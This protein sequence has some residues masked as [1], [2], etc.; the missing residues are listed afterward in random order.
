L[1]WA[2]VRD[3]L[4]SYITPQTPPSPPPVILLEKATF[5]LLY[6]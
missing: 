5:S 4:Y 6:L 1:F 3:H 2:L